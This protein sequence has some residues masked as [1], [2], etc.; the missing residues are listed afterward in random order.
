MFFCQKLIR[1][2]FYLSKKKVSFFSLVFIG[3]DASHAFIN[4][5]LKKNEIF[6][7]IKIINILFLET[8]YV[9]MC[10]PKELIQTMI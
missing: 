10:V 5:K 1:C 7:G 8:V 6:I 4:E 9:Y 2:D 3:L